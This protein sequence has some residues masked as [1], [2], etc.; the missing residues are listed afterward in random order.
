MPQAT[1]KIFEFRDGIVLKTYPIRDSPLRDRRKALL[2]RRDRPEITVLKCE[3]KSAQSY[4]RLR[5]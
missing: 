1:G 4:I 2:R 5:T 3:Q